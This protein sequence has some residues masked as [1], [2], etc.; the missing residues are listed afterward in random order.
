[1]NKKNRATALKTT[2][3]T[4]ALILLPSAAQAVEVSMSGQVNRLL[5]NVDNGVDSGVVHADNSV[6]GTR[7]RLKGDGELD[8]GMTAGLVYET[9]LQSNPSSEITADTLDSDGIGGNVGSGDYFSTRL[10]YVWLKG[11]FGKVAMGQNSGAADGSA[12]VDNSGTTVIQYSGS[13]ADLLG[14]MVYGN[15]GVTVGVARTNFDALSRYDNLRYDAGIQ[16]FTLAASIGNGDKFGAS[17]R[18]AIENF[19][20][21][22]GT[23]D[24]NDNGSGIAGN[25]MSAS[26]VADN[27]FNLTGAYG[28]D[29]REGDPE[30]FYFKVGYIMGDHAFGIDWGETRDFGPNDASSYSIAWVGSMMQGVEFY[31]SYRVESLDASG[32]DDIDALAGG[33]RIKF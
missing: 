17:V 19:G 22:F 29:D 25:S 3:A 28:S 6:S 20:F 9:Q 26:W 12:E 32:A 13:S 5:M 11:N 27:G 24:E 10:A 4:S 7:W 18:Y 33:A 23:W 1:M 16:N 30:N 14:S 2:L 21:M 31:A 15:T 8:N